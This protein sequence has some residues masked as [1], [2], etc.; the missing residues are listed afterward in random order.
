MAAD[1]GM[2]MK[3]MWEYDDPDPL[4]GAMARDLRERF[5]EEYSEEAFKRSAREGF[6]AGFYGLDKDE[7]DSG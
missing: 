4:D 2:T 7:T 1:Q 6:L 5:G 3:E